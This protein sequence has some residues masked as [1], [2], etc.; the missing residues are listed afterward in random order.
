MLAFYDIKTLKQ[1]MAYVS[2]QNVKFKKA[3]IAL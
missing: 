1:V 2:A 3:H